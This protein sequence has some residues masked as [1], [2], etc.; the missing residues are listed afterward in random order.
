MAMPVSSK[1][2]GYCKDGTD[3]HISRTV[4]SDTFYFDIQ[5][6]YMH[7]SQQMLLKES[8]KHSQ[9]LQTPQIHLFDCYPR[10]QSDLGVWT[11]TRNRF[12]M[13]K[14]KSVFY[15]YFNSI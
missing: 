11:A 2:T 3:L 14:V 12:V 7:N 4:I 6:K 8:N 10:N 15:S 5:G 13:S 1:F 9:L